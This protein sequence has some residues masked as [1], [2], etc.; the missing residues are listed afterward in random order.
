MFK[1][2]KQENKIE[3]I[4]GPALNNLNSLNQILVKIKKDCNIKYFANFTND[5]YYYFLSNRHFDNMQKLFGGL[6]RSDMICQRNFL[7]ML[8]FII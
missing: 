3:T 2:S 5:A 6:Q 4:I 1:K 7:L 8:L